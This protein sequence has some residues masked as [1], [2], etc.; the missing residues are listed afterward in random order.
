MRR[1]AL[2]LAL[3][4]GSGFAEETRQAKAGVKP[5][6]AT[7]ADLAWL[8][9][10]WEGK[11]LGGGAAIEVYSSPA[12]GQIPGHFRQLR[13]DGAIQFYEFVSITERD[14]TLHYRLK[15]F[16]PDLTGWE[17]KAVVREF[18][19]VAAEKDAW[20]FDGLTI[21][22]NGKDGLVTAVR[23]GNKDGTTQEAV[24]HYRRKP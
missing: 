15:H 22:R 12:G 1:L 23:I 8:E 19:L 21:R 3:L 14:G 10:T 4:S 24:F 16:N 7:V 2:C 18:T 17:E 20:Y 9:G 11:G 6:A 13:P 5:P